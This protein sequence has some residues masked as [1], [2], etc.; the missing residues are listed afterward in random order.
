MKNRSKSTAVARRPA[1]L[2]K[3]ADITR[4]DKLL[5]QLE[6]PNAHVQEQARQAM[7]VFTMQHGRSKCGAMAAH[8]D[9]GGG[10]VDG[11]RVEVQS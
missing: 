5:Q 8:L 10:L 11:P 4:F 9:A 6:Y 2:W 1:P 3:A 7:G